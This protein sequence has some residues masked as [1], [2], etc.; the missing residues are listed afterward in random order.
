MSIGLF[1]LCLRTRPDLLRNFRKR[2]I[3]SVYVILESSDILGLP[4][5][6]DLVLKKIYGVRVDL[7]AYRMR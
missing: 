1:R 2:G 6:Y 7:R 5:S 4:R 3:Q